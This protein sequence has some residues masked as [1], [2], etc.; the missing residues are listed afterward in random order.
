[1]KKDFLEGLKL[2]EKVIAAILAESE[3]DSAESAKRLA[4][5]D[6]VKKQLENANATIEKFS[7]YQQTKA[8]VEKYKA[9]YQKLKDKSAAKIAVLE[10]SAKINEF[11]TGKKFA[12]KITAEAVKSKLSD[13]LVDSANAGKS[14]KELFE[15]LL[16]DDENILMKENAPTPP[17]VEK[18]GGNNGSV[19]LIARL[20]LK[21]RALWA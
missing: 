19:R 12:N 8:E 9:D 20:T 21:L 6:D 15:G 5:Y 16:K 7:D 1:M 10:R 17:V 13:M 2:D 11:L 3:K 14:V 4:D 18:L